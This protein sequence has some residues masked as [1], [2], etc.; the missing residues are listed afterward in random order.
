M[1]LKAKKK[2]TGIWDGRRKEKGGEN[3]IIKL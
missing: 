1:Y 2:G 3:N